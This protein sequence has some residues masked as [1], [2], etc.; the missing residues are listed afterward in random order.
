[1]KFI[2]FSIALHTIIFISVFTF[3]NKNSFE[4]Q[5]PGHNIDAINISMNLSQKIV[6]EK[7]QEESVQ[8][9]PEIK[10]EP[11]VVAKPKPK[12]EAKPREIPKSKAIKKASTNKTNTEVLPS[13]SNSNSLIELSKGI[14]AAKNQ[15]VKGLEYKFISQPDPEYPLAAKRVGYNKKIS[16]K[17]R[18]LVGLD[19]RVEEV[20]FYN[21]KDSLGFQAEVEKV[22][23]EWKLTQVTLDKKPIKLYFYKEFKFDQI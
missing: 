5:N 16:I 23:K 11:D 13:N 17:V 7:T 20:K 9:E 1:M 3:D 12:V 14:F 22:L 21:E 2:I 4:I 8:S 10:A 19:G 6:P 15:G 18:F